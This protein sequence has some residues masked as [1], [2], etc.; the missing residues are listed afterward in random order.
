MLNIG[1]KNKGEIEFIGK[2]YGSKAEKI[3]TLEELDELKEEIQ[4]DLDGNLDKEHLLE[5]LSDVIVMIQHLINVYKFNKGDIENQITH[6]VNRQ[7]KRIQ[8]EEK[9]LL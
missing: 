2:Y 9:A 4:K 1:Y 3:K 7:L 5:E 8:E 6:K